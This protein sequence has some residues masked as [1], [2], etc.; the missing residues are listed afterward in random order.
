M[1]TL[2]S[3][4]RRG[5]PLCLTFAGLLEDG[6]DLFLPF[7]RPVVDLYGMSEKPMERSSRFITY[8][9]FAQFVPLVLFPWDLSIRSVVFALILLL[10]SAFLGWSLLQR[11]PW[12]RK[13]T[14]FVQGLNIVVRIITFFG[15]VYGPEAG[16]N[17][18]LLV[19]YLLAIVLSGAILSYIDRPEVQ[20]AFEA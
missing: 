6:L 16:L 11:K 13:M 8:I 3:K 1:P 20:L 19:T 17:A 14:I 10:L 15:N 9:A 12:G 18:P 5:V 4:T 2:G 7:F